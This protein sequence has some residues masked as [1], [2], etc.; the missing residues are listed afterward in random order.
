MSTFGFAKC[1]I[2]LPIHHHF[3]DNSEEGG[4]QLL[5]M[6]VQL[7]NAVV[8]GSGQQSAKHCPG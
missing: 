8:C 4:Q 7:M 1:S 5:P 3:H 2:F 6:C